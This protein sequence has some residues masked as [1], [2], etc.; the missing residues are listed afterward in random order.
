MEILLKDW[1][2]SKISSHD[3]FKQKIK[4]LEMIFWN[5]SFPVKVKVSFLCRQN[6]VILEQNESKSEI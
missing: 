4:N 5:F 1:F 3:L 6:Q 2:F